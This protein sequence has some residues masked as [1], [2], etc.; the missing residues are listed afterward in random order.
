MLIAFT[1]QQQPYMLKCKTLP[2]EKLYGSK[3]ARRIFRILPKTG[4]L[5]PTSEHV[6]AKELP[7]LTGKTNKLDTTTP[8]SLTGVV[9]PIRVEWP[10]PAGNHLKMLITGTGHPSTAKQDTAWDRLDL[11]HERVL[12]ECARQGRLLRILDIGI[13]AGNEWESSRAITTRRLA[14]KLLSA[15]PRTEIIGL[16]VDLSGIVMAIAEKEGYPPYAAP[17]LS[18]IEADVTVTLGLPPSTLDMVFCFNT[19][20]FMD[21]AGILAIFRNVFAALKPGGKFLYCGKYRYWRYGDST[22][23][24]QELIKTEEAFPEAWAKAAEEVYRLTEGESPARFM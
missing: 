23:D 6:K 18:Y 9:Y 20:G 24:I 22:K 10:T 2:P 4:K 15:S 19:L 17:N 21:R 11:I 14:Q 12:D 8:P 16:D 13:G 1:A 5:G 3:Y 7:P